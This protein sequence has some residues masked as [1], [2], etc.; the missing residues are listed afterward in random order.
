MDVLF[1][2]MFTICV[3]GACGSKKRASDPP[4][5]GLQTFVSLQME[6]EN[7]IWV[8]KQPVP[9]TTEPSLSSPWPSALIQILTSMNLQAGLSAPQQILPATLECCVGHGP[10]TLEYIVPEIS[11]SG[12][13]FSLCLWFCFGGADDQTRDLLYATQMCYHWATSNLAIPF[14]ILSRY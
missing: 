3:S 14:S 2:C 11:F 13:F 9:L 12:S 5:L 10:S 6:S 1:E 7:W 4:E 8:L